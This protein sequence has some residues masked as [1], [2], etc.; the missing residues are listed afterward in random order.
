RVQAPEIEP[1]ARCYTPYPCE[2]WDRC[3][4]SKPIDWVFRMPN[5]GATRRAELKTLG[6]E[7]IAAIP[8]DFRL[9]R[10]QAIIREVIRSGKVF[11]GQDL[12]EHLD[13]FGPPAYYLDFETFMPAVPLYR[14]TRP[15]QV[16]PFQWSLHQLEAGGRIRHQDFLADG[17]S[18]PRR[19]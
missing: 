4:Q 17:D 9:S 10:R 13:G 8:D 5:L 19:P 15:Y 16:I 2:H 6:V 12:S 1:E 18:D 7:S 11:V 3:T 14:G